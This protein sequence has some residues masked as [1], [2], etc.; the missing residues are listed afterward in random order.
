M[1]FTAPVVR[2]PDEAAFPDYA[3]SPIRASGAASLSISLS[4]VTPDPK[5]PVAFWGYGPGELTQ[6]LALKKGAAP[7][8]WTRNNFV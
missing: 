7:D 8:Q 5:K 6:P 2:E 1:S 3:A 4:G